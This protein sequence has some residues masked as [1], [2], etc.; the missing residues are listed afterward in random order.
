MKGISMAQ[1]WLS[2]EYQIAQEA[3]SELEGVLVFLK[4]EEGKESVH[5]MRVMFRR[6]YSIWGVLRR[7]GW[8]TEKYKKGLG[9]DIRLAYKILGKIREYDVMCSLSKKIGL[10]DDVVNAF[11]RKRDNVR[12]KL[13]RQLSKIDLS[14]L[15]KRLRRYLTEREQILDIKFKARSRFLRVVGGKS[16]A[17]SGKSKNKMRKARKMVETEEHFNIVLAEHERRT[18]DLVARAHTIE[19]LHD[20]RL[21]VKAW[22]YLLVEFFDT[23]HPVLVKAQQYLGKVNDL[24]HLASFL[25]TKK[26]GLEPHLIKKQISI[27]LKK[28]DE[29]RSKFDQLKRSLPYGFRP[30]LPGMQNTASNRA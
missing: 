30:G 27:T 21:S 5:D 11:R 14:K 3:V 22:R 4:Q 16:S 9:R 7:D 19:E 17:K 13:V 8:E 12:E 10:C 25:E 18:A 2:M 23:T 15:F 6:W 26:L 28:R 29:M 24:D 1:D 20:V